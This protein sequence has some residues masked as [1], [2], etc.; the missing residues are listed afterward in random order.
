M[1]HTSIATTWKKG[2]IE[3]MIQPNRNKSEWI[4]DIDRTS[5]FLQCST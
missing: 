2:T 5:D 1:K 4:P 3:R